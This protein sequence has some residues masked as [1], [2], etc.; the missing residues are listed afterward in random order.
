MGYEVFLIRLGL[1][2]TVTVSYDLCTESTAGMTG[3]IAWE[4]V[5]KTTDGKIASFGTGNHAA[6]ESN[7]MR[8][9]DPV[10][11]P[12]HVITYDAFP[13]TQAA[14]VNRYVSNYDNHPSLYIPTVG[15]KGVA[16]WIGHGLFDFDASIWSYGDREPLLASPLSLFMSGITGLTN[17][18]NPAVAWCDQLGIGVWYGSSTGG[19]TDPYN[20]RIVEPSGTTPPWKVTSHDLTASIAPH[21]LC[22]ARNEGAVIGTD[23]YVHGQDG[24]GAT[25][26]RFYK[27]NLVT[28]AVTE[29]TPAPYEIDYF[30]Q[31]VYDSGRGKLI[32]IGKKLREY[33]PASDASGWVDISPT[34]WT[35][36]QNVMGVY[37]STLNA[38]FFRGMR[39]HDVYEYPANMRWHRIAALGATAPD[40]PAAP[41]N[42]R[43]V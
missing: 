32:R 26:N 12:G 16:A 29:L 11:V 24:Y 31:I 2:S 14:G 10:T 18:Y 38:I 7:A 4:S 19:S 20:L 27:I 25:S 35:G 30:P 9:V 22:Y 1:P 6:E 34:G 39:D 28:F 17:F 23:F 5:F 33:N 3:A 8:I 43:I 21:A 36:Y 15:T 37:H 40:V 13:W 42:M 41:A